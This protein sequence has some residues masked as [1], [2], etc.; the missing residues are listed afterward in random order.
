[1]DHLRICLHI[2]LL[3]FQLASANYTP[4]CRAPQSSFRT[5][6][7][8]DASCNMDQLRI[9]LQIIVKFQL[10]GR[11]YAPSCRAPQ[12]TCRIHLHIVLNATVRNVINDFTVTARGN[13][14]Y[15]TT[16]CVIWTGSYYTTTECTQFFI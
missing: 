4:S 13:G 7:T 15:Y 6:L 9:C 2:I 12:S 8:H 14:P 10:A 5:R 16:Q 11:N 3:K 1:M